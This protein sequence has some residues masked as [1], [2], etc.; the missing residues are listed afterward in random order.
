[1]V[2]NGVNVPNIRP[3]QELDHLWVADLIGKRWGSVRVVTRGRVHVVT[4]LPGFVAVRARERVGLITYR[5]SED[6][7]EI[8]TLDSLIERVGIG[9]ALLDQV[10]AAARSQ[11]CKRLWLIT[12]NDNVHAVRFYQKRGFALAA[13][14]RNALEVSRRLKPEIPLVGIDGIPL[15]DE[16]ELEMLLQQARF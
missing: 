5:I 16:V 9:S 10:K 2:E 13:V 4:Q 1:V 6:E 15:R 8:V 7:C 12:T 14:Y 11:S 3:L